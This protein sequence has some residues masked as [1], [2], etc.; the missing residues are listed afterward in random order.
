MR[1]NVNKLVP[2]IQLKGWSIPRLE[3]Y[4]KHIRSTVHNLNEDSEDGW[5]F[6]GKSLED[7]LNT[8]TGYDKE[9]YKNYIQYNK[10]YRILIKIIDF[11]KS[12]GE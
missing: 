2:L 12:K 3:R 11:K 8:L 6:K 10:Y 5:F 1:R 4:K 7:Q 9:R